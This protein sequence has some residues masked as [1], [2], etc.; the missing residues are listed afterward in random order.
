M[1]Y[2]VTAKLYLDSANRRTTILCGTFDTVAA[3]AAFVAGND[4]IPGEEF[5]IGSFDPEFDV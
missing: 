5:T 2:T 3:A 4:P 1:V